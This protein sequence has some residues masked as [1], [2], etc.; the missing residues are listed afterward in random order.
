M[1]VFVCRCHEE[2]QGIP[3]FVLPLFWFDQAMP[4]KKKDLVIIHVWEN[5]LPLKS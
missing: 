2:N 4:E 3:C 1:D 5:N